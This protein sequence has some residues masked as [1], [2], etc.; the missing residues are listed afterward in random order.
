MF[1]LVVVSDLI[2]LLIGS[3]MYESQG[4]VG[5]LLV[6]ETSGQSLIYAGIPT[7]LFITVPI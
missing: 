5:F 7:V 6:I 2:M 1:L 4:F 3:L